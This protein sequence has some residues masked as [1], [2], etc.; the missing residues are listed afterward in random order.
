MTFTDPDMKRRCTSSSCPRGSPA[1]K[2]AAASPA[3]AS[4]DAILSVSFRVGRYIIVGPHGA[5]AVPSPSKG[6]RS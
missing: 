4:S 2:Q 6:P 5:A 1:W 3:F